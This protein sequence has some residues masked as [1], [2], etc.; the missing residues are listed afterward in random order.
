MP[1]VYETIWTPPPGFKKN[2]HPLV[3]EMGLPIKNSY[4]LKTAVLL[5]EILI[6]Q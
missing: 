5:N 4:R 2:A 6:S 1:S 3:V